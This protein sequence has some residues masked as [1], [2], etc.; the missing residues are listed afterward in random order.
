MSEG[1]RGNFEKNNKRDR[2]KKIQREI[3]EAE[4]RELEE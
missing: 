1:E 4:R 2:K 3:R